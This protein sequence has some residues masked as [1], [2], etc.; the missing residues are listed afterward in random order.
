[1]V[2]R[3]PTDFK[4]RIHPDEYR[5]FTAKKVNGDLAMDLLMEFYRLQ[6]SHYI[7]LSQYCT[8]LEIENKRLRE[9]NEFLTRQLGE[10]QCPE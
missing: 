5:K 7:P 3:R 1:M 9:E 6:N 10:Y 8:Y 4:D 2:T